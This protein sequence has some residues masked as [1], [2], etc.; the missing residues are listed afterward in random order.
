MD[1]F[2][3][4]HILLSGWKWYLSN[5]GELGPILVVKIKCYRTYVCI[6]PQR[7]V[8]TL[9]CWFSCTGPFAYLDFE[10]IKVSSWY[11]RESLL[12]KIH[13]NRLV[14]AR[15]CLRATNTFNKEPTWIFSSSRPNF[16]KEQICSLQ[17]PF[18]V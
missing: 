11:W 14:H 5:I 4:N 7:L 6:V 12:P 3:K 9:V 16:L 2:Q 8:V 15:L 17:T 18:I 10:T 13:L 1:Y